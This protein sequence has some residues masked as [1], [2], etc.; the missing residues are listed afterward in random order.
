MQGCYF[1]LT[2]HKTGS[3]RIAYSISRFFVLARVKS[4]F[5]TDSKSGSPISLFDYNEGYVVITGHL[6]IE[7]LLDSNKQ[8]RQSHQIWRR[9]QRCSLS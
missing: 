6:R 7:F 9:L 5:K 8:E 4:I 3:I 1:S 2:T